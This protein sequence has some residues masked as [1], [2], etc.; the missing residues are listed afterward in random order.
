VHEHV[1]HE[2][3]FAHPLVACG[4]VETLWREVHAAQPTR[5]KRSA[6]GAHT[7]L[8]SHAPA[9]A[10]A[11][12]IAEPSGLDLL[13]R[14]A[15][16]D[17]CLTDSTKLYSS[18]IVHGNY[19]LLGAALEAQGYLYLRGVLLRLGNDRQ[20]V[21]NMMRSAVQQSQHCRSTVL[22]IAT[23]Q[24]IAVDG[25]DG[26]LDGAWMGVAQSAALQEICSGLD[27]LIERINCHTKQH[28]T[29]LPN[30]S[31]LRAHAPGAAATPPSTDYLHFRTHQLDIFGS[32]FRPRWSTPVEQQCPQQHV[33]QLL[34]RVQSIAAVNQLR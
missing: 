11:A 22:D 33:S 29:T 17:G 28:C 1:T 14:S 19:K 30:C 21:H 18:C 25:C 9:A 27:K 5:A 4:A 3:D 15:G 16:L 6:N 24:R 7:P 2:R 23:S 26:S 34:C 32:P 12:P 8:M 13:V 31:W 10:A 20:A